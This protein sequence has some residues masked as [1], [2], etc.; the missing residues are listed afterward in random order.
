MRAVMRALAAAVLLGVVVFAGVY[1]LNELVW[2]FIPVG[3]S[4]AWATGMAV[5]AA[6]FTFVD[7]LRHG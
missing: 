5:F 4:A 2:D 1:A 6:A 7:Q 3:S